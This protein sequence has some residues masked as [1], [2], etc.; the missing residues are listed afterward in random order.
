[1]LFQPRSLQQRTLFFIL[2]P[3]FLLLVTTSLIGFVFIRNILVKQWGETA[4]ASLQR[5]A[6]QIDMR[7]R[8]PKDI[9]TLLPKG[10]SGEAERLLFTVIIKELEGLDG[11]MGV[12]VQWFERDSEKEPG[13]KK[14]KTAMEAMTLRQEP[15]HFFLTA[16]KF[17]KNLKNRTVS[18]VSEF[19]N[20]SDE[21][22]GQIKVAI[23][24]DALV[25]EIIN[26]SWWKNNNKAYLIDDVGNV[27]ASAAQ[28]SELEDS[29]PLR[30]F[31]TVNQ[32]EE[33]TLTAMRA[34]NF[35]TVFG[36][37]YPPEEI[38]GYYCLH[39][40]PW[41]MVIIA[42]GAQVLQPILHF[43]LFYI[44]SF[45]LAIVV[46]LVV[47]RTTVSRL[48]ARIKEI[49]AAAESLAGGRFGSPLMVTSRDEV[50]ELTVSFN[51]M[52]RQLQQRLRMKEE[53]N[54]ARE[55][56]QNLLPQSG[57]SAAGI[58]AAGISLYCDETGGDYFDFIDFVDNDRK[59]GVAV[60][61]VVG[62]GLGAALMM[63]TVRALLR[64]RIFQF[65]ALDAIMA[66]VNR[67]LCRDTTISGSF[68]TLFYI[69]V[70]R[71]QNSLSWVRAGHEPAIVYTPADGK[72]SEFKGQGVALGVD[73]NATFQY[74]QML[75][76]AV[77]PLIILIGS[78][79]VWEVENGVGE[80]F[81]KER[82]KNILAAGWKQH[83]EEIVQ[84]LVQ[85]IAA[86]R[87]ETQQRD[88]IT[89]VVVKTW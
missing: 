64:C 40:V 79:G 26:S 20:D 89:L 13:S 28:Q 8:Q 51:K 41:T 9:L 68:V 45:S 5:T 27:L 86:F 6:H 85:E 49:S 62:H 81:G 18:L 61:D 53:I 67:L 57:F 10:L 46:I 36:E 21:T 84:V 29:F 75:V 17:D 19:K 80:Q 70:D 76:S 83:P 60:G 33:K 63:T 25:G 69:E 14:E 59:V 39:E 50:G 42:P 3:T 4:I 38:S 12:E 82:V 23:S 78:D 65:G 1:M 77:E 34:A 31:G 74:N 35:G 16:P 66:D 47:I 43:R 48:T 52:T 2:V 58:A 56:Q 11:V 24:F 55:V 87:G 71:S 72:F 22:L 32:L 44:L 88:D 30:A 54:V 37:G 7:L 15:N 73:D